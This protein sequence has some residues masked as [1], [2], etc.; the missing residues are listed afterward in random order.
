MGHVVCNL[1]E[2]ERKVFDELRIGLCG[3]PSFK[4]FGTRLC[5]F[6]CV[7][8]AAWLDVGLSFIGPLPP[9]NRVAWMCRCIE[10][11]VWERPLSAAWATV[12]IVTPSTGPQNCDYVVFGDPKTYTRYCKDN[13]ILPSLAD[14]WL[15]QCFINQD[16]LSIYGHEHY[17]DLEKK[18]N[19]STYKSSR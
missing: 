7:Q 3:P 10:Q 6:F 13:V 14:E 2:K 19:Q 17:T 16:V 5:A 1:P 11:A 9:T 4:V 15:I 12:V 18:A 8:S